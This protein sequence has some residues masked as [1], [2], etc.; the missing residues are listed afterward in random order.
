MKQELNWP[1]IQLLMIKDWQL[2]Q[3]QLAVYLL[4]GIVSLTLLGTAKPWA[5][6]LGSLLLIILLVAIAC[7]AVSNSL[8]NERRDQTLAFVMS[9]P[10]SPLD[11]TVAKLA[12]NLLTFSVPFLAMALFTAIIIFSTP[13]PNGLIVLAALIFGHVLMAYCISLTVAMKVESEGWNI[14]VMIGSM[15]LINPFLMALGQMDSVQSVVRGN[16]V[17]WHGPVLAIL[18]TQVLIGLACLGFALWSNG[19]KPAF[20]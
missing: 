9:L 17:I 8:M 16:P 4:G 11:F 1:V 15:V 3:K 12:G 7:F 20:Y 2:F 10:V 18:A 19:R 6:Y 14:F 5:F 13:L